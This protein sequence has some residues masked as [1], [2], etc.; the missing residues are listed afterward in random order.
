MD[1][2]SPGVWQWFQNV[3]NLNNDVS[4]KAFLNKCNPSLQLVRTAISIVALFVFIYDGTIKLMYLNCTSGNQILKLKCTKMFYS[5]I[6]VHISIT[7][8]II[9]SLNYT[10]ILK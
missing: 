5:H 8:L 1:K 4:F 2:T 9:F 10:T 3:Y 7:D 6:C